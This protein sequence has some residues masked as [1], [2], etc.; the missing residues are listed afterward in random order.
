[1]TQHAELLARYQH[2]RQVGLQLNNRL[3]QTLS[4]SVLNEGGQR[5]GILKKNVL[6]LDSEDEMAVLMDYC[7]HDVRRQGANAIERYLAE[8]PPPPDSDE[9]LLLQALRQARY[10]LFAVESV[11]PGVGVHVRDLLRDESLFLV[12]V[13]FSRTAS[14]GMILAARVMMPGGI[15]MTTGAALPVGLLSPA[16]RARFLQNLMTIFKDIDFR[17]LLPEEASELAAAL[18]RTCLQQG[19]AARIKYIEPRL[20]S[21]RSRGSAAPPPARRVGRNERCPCGSGRKF[22]HCC[23]ARR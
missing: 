3:V 11:E 8:S 22:K 6:V 13:G 23:G 4:R 20:G 12:D 18:I 10:S 2:L 16:E 7:I 14:V 9:M 17:R 21:G 15:G 1:M 5:L 19:A